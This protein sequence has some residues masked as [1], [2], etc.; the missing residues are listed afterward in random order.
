MVKAY[1]QRITSRKKFNAEFAAHQQ[2]LPADWPG[3]AKL[4]P[5]HAVIEKS[6]HYIDKAMKVQMH[7]SG[8]AYLESTIPIRQ[9]SLRIKDTAAA[10]KELKDALAAE[11]AKALFD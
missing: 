1:K 2:D 9:L 11:A 10:I 3:K 7:E 6:Y 5:C 8:S 4:G